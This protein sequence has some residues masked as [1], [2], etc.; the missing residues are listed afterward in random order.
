M[1]RYLMLL[2]AILSLQ[3]QASEPMSVEQKEVWA[4]EEAYWKYVSDRD[5]DGFMTLWDE[6]FVGWPCDALA[7]KNYKGLRS[8]VAEWFAEVA[9][10]SSETVIEPE[11]V[12][13][14][15][16]FAITYLAATTT[17]A[18]EA[19]GAEVTSIKIVHTWRRTD[20]GWKIIGGMC[21]PLDR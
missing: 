1:R 7:P 15:E 19:T 5:V 17:M 2:V 16:Q 18:R 14:D 6:R 8:S 21:G 11:A 9:A 12:I 13:V 3:T 10:V 4:G 20:I